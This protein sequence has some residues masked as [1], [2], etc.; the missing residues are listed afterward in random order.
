MHRSGTSVLTH[1]LHLLGAEVGNELLAAEESINAK[2]FWEH[3]RVVDLNERL[4]RA[5]DR[6]WYD[7]LPL[8]DHW[9]EI[10]EARELQK[11]AVTFLEQDLGKGEL[12][13]IKDPRLCLLLPFWASAARKAGWTPVVVLALRNPEEVAASLCRRDPLVNTVAMLLWLRYLRDAE[14]HSRALPRSAM[15]YLQLLE[16]GPETLHRIGER[17]EIRW[18]RSPVQLRDA[19]KEI[20]DPDLRH[21]HSSGTEEN[22]ELTSLAMGVYQQLTHATTSTEALDR[23]WSRFDEMLGK[24]AGMADALSE[25]NREL[26]SLDGRYQSLGNEHARALEVIAE[27]DRTLQVRTRE[28]ESMGKDLEYCRSVVE[29][30]DR[31]LECLNDEIQSCNEKTQALD[32]EMEQMETRYEELTKLYRQLEENHQRLSDEHNA[33]ISHPSIRIVRKLFLRNKP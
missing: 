15:D 11:E 19:I 24:C 20:I 25:T 31:Q 1:L 33:L 17:L 8:P 12:A 29:E 6:N 22:D 2:G 3:R 9:T 28:W 26:F 30:R 14:V 21:Q 7:F 5:L 18:P 16:D 13:A 27:R 23:L 10:A 4:L 32:K